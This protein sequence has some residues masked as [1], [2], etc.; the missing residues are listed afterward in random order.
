MDRLALQSA[1]SGKFFTQP[2]FLDEKYILL[3]PETPLTDELRNRLVKWGYSSLLCDGHPADESPTAPV[4]DAAEDAPLIDLEQGV[5][6]RE[7]LKEAQSTYA[8]MLNFTEKTF[9]NFA[10]KNELS[11]RTVSERIK[12][13]VETVKSHRKYLLRFSALRNLDKNYIV[14]HSVRTT[15]LSA[16]IGATLRIP[17]HKLIE[18]GTAAILHEIGMIRLPPQ[19]YL[20]TRELTAQERKAI[21]AHT[22]LGF[23][24]LKQYSFPLSVCL[25]VLECRENLDGTG[26]PRGLTAERIS[27]YAK[28]IA[29]AGSYAAQT[30]ERPY[31]PARDPHQAMLELIKGRGTKYDEH[32][33]RALIANLSIY[34]LGTYVELAN[35]YRGM[36][37]ESNNDNPRAPIVRLMVSAEGHRYADQPSVRTTEEQYQIV[38]TL[39]P[40][41]T[42]ELL[43]PSS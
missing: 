43:E 21:L 18:L 34:P 4:S 32:V 31:R 1:T 9:T 16:S 24:I 3:S 19:V 12:D 15:I 40:E 10:T 33:L 2:V 14:E 8:Q 13:L 11:Q 28:I 36:V 25:A 29:V 41:E 38:R 22:V 5:R 37:V 7:L 30:A 39:T 23:K 20:S 42:Q 35:G 17:A 26:Y 27:Q 6:E